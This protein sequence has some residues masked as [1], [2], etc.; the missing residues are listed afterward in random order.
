MV[1]ATAA[2]MLSL[3]EEVVQRD[4]QRS[5]FGMNLAALWHDIE[6]GAYGEDLPL[7]RSLAHMAG[8][9]VVDVGAGTGRVSLDL[10]RGGVEVVALD[11]CAP[12]LDALEHRAAGLP[13]RT[14]VA[15][16]RDFT[17]GRRFPLVL[18]PMQT[19]QMLGGLSGRAAFLQRAREHLKP[20]G[21]VAA[22]VADA[23][24]CF[25]VEHD[26]PPPP[27]IREIVDVRYAS[28]L[29]A[30]VNEGGRAAIHRRREII[31]PGERYQFHDV[32]VRLD[33]VSADE[34]AAE[35]LQHRF[36]AEPHLFVPQTEQYLGSTVVVLRAT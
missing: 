13:I 27:D 14:V 29:L 5:R 11:A 7:W 1:R 33:R 23:M 10:A 6:C 12:L 28:Q 3:R 20:G 31:G 34:V 21:L 17:L 8:G 19:L 24:D 15:D 32:V 26:T 2:R 35:A 25:D 4:A 22:A 36:L 16:A 9:P 30:I 18:I